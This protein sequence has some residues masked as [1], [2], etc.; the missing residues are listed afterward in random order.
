[1]RTIMARLK[2]EV[3]DDE[4]MAKLLEE[5]D[6]DGD[7]IVQWGEFLLT[8]ETRNRDGAHSSLSLEGLNDLDS[9]FSKNHILIQK[10][11]TNDDDLNPL[12]RTHAFRSHP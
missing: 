3:L 7:G 9:I 12:V 5:F 8:M 1:M 2:G 4:E 6:H 11:E 10:R